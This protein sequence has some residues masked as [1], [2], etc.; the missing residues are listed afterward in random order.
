MSTF[1]GLQWLGN[2][3][4][5]DSLDTITLQDISQNKLQKLKKENKRPSFPHCLVALSGDISKR[6]WENYH[7]K[8]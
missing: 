6:S 5:L 8:Q 2:F 4:Y 3:I 1:W 7:M